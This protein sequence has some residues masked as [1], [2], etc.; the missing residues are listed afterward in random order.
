MMEG[1]AQARLTSSLLPQGYGTPQLPQLTVL[2]LLK[3]MI[4]LKEKG[5]IS[6]LS[7]DSNSEWNTGMC[8]YGLGHEYNR[9]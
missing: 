1:A 6:D 2:E 8:E 3:G 5:L 7:F 9:Q 4:Q